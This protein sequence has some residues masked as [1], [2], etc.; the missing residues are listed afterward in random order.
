MSKKWH[1]FH[2]R[3]PYTVSSDWALN[4][5]VITHEKR[6]TFNVSETNDVDKEEE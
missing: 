3:M 2:I 1:S 4:G 5:P 6:M